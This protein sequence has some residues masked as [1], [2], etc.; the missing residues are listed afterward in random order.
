M[1]LKEIAEWMNQHNKIDGYYSNW[2]AESL[3]KHLESTNRRP[4]YQTGGFEFRKTPKGYRIVLPERSK[5]VKQQV[6]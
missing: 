3:E 2:D 1:N 5:F 6:K 4:I